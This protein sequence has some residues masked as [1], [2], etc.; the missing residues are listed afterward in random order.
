MPIGGVEIHARR[1]HH[2][3][4]LQHALAESHGIVAE[5]ADIGIEV[6]GAVGRRE[7]RDAETRQRGEQGVAVA[8]V[9]QHA[10]LQFPVGIQ[11]GDTGKLGERRRGNLQAAMQRLDARHQPFGQHQPAEPPP[12]HAPVFRKAVDHDGV[13]AG[14]QDRVGRLV[15]GDAVIQLVDDQ[16]QA[17][18]AAGFIDGAQFGRRQH[19]AGGIRRAGDHDAFHLRRQIGDHRR[20]DLEARGG[21]GGNA[22]RDQV[23]CFQRAAIGGITG[24]HHR[25]GVAGG[26]AGEESQHEA[27][28]RA[29]GDRHARRRNIQ[30]MTAAIQVRDALAQR[31]DA[32]RL[33][34]AKLPSAAQRLLGGGDGG[35]RRRQGRLA[36]QQIHHFAAGFHPRIHRLEDLP[37]LVNLHVAAR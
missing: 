17:A 25:H 21:I 16:P 30:A 32:Q 22:M 31:H 35:L 12:G 26:K 28:R 18:L 10:G 34:V 23:E 4:F 20:R 14:G 7:A 24:F 29:D 8:P 37:H 19:G 3:G 15:V 2:A 9:G 27:R 13:V 36:H 6:E 1:G 33:G 11:G 5:I